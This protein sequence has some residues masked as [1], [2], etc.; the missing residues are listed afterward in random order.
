MICQQQP[1]GSSLRTSGPDLPIT[2]YQSPITIHV[3]VM[4]GIVGYIGRKTAAP[5]LIEGLRRLE[6]RGY[7]S[8]GLCTLDNGPLQVRKCVGRVARLAQL[9][10]EKPVTG[11]LGISHTRWATHGLPSDANAHPHLDRSGQ[12]ALVHNGIIEN[13]AALRHKLL[14]AR[15]KFSS[16][17]DTEVLAHVIGHHLARQLA[18]GKPLTPELVANAVLSGAR[19]AQGTYAIALVHAQLP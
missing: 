17:T 4:C 12:L 9:L 1:I 3:S 5:L 16:Q 8:S 6:Y 15:H 10:A 14:L 19:Q 18:K 7:D 11:S 2:D 13:Y